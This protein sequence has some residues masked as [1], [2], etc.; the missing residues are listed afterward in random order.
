[1]AVTLTVSQWTAN[2][3]FNGY[4]KRSSADLSVKKKQYV[5]TVCAKHF[6]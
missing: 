5:V 4:F 3:L 2:I 1:M 6:I